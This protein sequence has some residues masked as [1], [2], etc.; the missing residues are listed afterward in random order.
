[1][2]KGK[3]VCDKRAFQSRFAVLKAEV[4]KVIAFEPT[5]RGVTAVFCD[6]YDPTTKQD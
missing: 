2:K 6:G 4:A 1:M 3:I 5:G